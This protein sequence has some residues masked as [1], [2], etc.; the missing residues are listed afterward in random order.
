MDPF[1]SSFMAISLSDTLLSF[2][3]LLASFFLTTIPIPFFLRSLRCKIVCS[4]IQCSL[5]YSLSTL[6][7]VVTVCLHSFVPSSLPVLFP[8]QLLFPYLRYP[9]LRVSVFFSTLPVVS[10][11]AFCLSFSFCFRYVQ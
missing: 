4:H 3:T 5:L 9:P 11:L 1:T 6:F 8:F 7:L 2:R 10:S